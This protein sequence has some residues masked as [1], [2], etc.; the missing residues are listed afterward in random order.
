MPLQVPDSEE[1]GSDPEYGSH[2]GAYTFHHNDLVFDCSSFWCH[3]LKSGRWP[4]NPYTGII[5]EISHSHPLVRELEVRQFNAVF[6][7]EDI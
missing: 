4:Q 1:S 3:E 2:P 7:L 6:N 5:I